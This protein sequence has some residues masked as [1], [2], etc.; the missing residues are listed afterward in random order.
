VHSKFGYSKFQN[1]YLH[2]YVWDETIASRGAQEI[3]S[4]I[5]KHVKKFKKR[6]KD[7]SLQ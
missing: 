7:Y 4:G 6:K 3:A 5:L 2:K 1:N